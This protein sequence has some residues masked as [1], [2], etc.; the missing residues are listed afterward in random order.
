MDEWDTLGGK[1]VLKPFKAAEGDDPWAIDP[2][3]LAPGPA[4]P[5]AKTD[6][7]SI[8]KRAADSAGAVASGF[9]RAYLSRAGLPFNPV[10][11]AANVIDLGKAAIGQPML[12]AGAQ[13]PSWMEP[14]PREQ[15]VG[16]GPWLVNQARK[17]ALGRA[18]LDAPNQADNG[19]LLQAL[20]GGVGGGVGGGASRAQEVVNGGIG[21]LS[22]GAS[23]VVGGMTGDPS[24]AM[25]AGMAPQ[26]GVMAGSGAVKLAIRG[27][28]AGR[29]EMEQRIQDLKAAGV[30]RPTLG[31]ASG[32]KLIGGIENLLQ[33]TPG[34]VG[35]MQRGR[36]AAVSGMQATAGLAAD[37]ASTNRG[38]MESGR[39]IQAGAAKFKADFKDQQAKLYDRL[40]QYIGQQTPVDVTNT[41]NTISSLNADIP[42][43]PA[44]SK[45]FKNSRI[46]AIESAIQSDIDGQAA[47]A[48]SP[49]QLKAALDSGAKD[50][51]SLNA[52]LGEG[53][54]LPFEAVKKTRTLVG[55]EIADNNFASDVPRSKWNPLYGA[56]S[57]DLKGA[58]AKA[59]PDA[60]AAFS[61][62]NDYTR[63]GIARLDRIDPVVDRKAPEQSYAALAQTLKENVSTFQAVKKSLPQDARGDFAATIIERLG[64]AK[65]GQQDET[66]TKW[67]PET[68]LTNWSSIKPQ[69][70]AELL[71]GIPNAEAVAESVNAVARAAAMMR[72][73]SKM[74][75]NPSGTGANV[76]ARSML[77][78]LGIGGAGAATGLVSPLVPLAAGGAMLGANVLARG[79]LS[80]RV[81]NFASRPS[82]PADLLDPRNQGLLQQ[83]VNVPGMTGLLNQQ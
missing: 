23:H 57:E 24:W 74:W 52:A 7:R 15:V 4:T 6:D 53:R 39:S 44:L 25:L 58:A 70:R 45:Q 42:G 59:G 80:D 35:V 64:K 20:G 14:S 30:E 8:L 77:G 66:G 55:G 78:G 67:S 21:A 81:R 12:W 54:S 43:A 82:V 13:V 2:K 76:A 11:V 60:A 83:L 34:A 69:A 9:N 19:G 71:S 1:P 28:E 75:A 62:A 49:S 37:L 16:S 72:D 18:A 51:A 38:A 65:P 41:R 50:A 56:L 46:Q 63:A 61:R 36:D 33:N 31:L 3:L 22:A 26:A 73:N 48:Y 5:T 27:G 79:L 10:D 68:F 47:R 17:T 29:R 40:D 32:N